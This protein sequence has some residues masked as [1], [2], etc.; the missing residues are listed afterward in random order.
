MNDFKREITTTDE[1]LDR[2]HRGESAVE[3]ALALDLNVGEVKTILRR[4][5]AGEDDENTEAEAYAHLTPEEREERLEGAA[6]V[7]EDGGDA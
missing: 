6:D 7:P 5:H 1:V 2:H 3:I 4:W